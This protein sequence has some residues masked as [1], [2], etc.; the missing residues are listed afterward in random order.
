MAVSRKDNN[1]QTGPNLDRI[2]QLVERIDAKKQVADDARSDLGTIFK[3][4]EDLGH[5]R[6]A[7]KLAIKL[8]NM[9]AGKRT[10]FMTRLNEY[11]DVL[12][13][14]A[15]GDL[16][17]D[18]EQGVGPRQSGDIDPYQAGKK[19]GFVGEAAENNPFDDDEPAHEAWSKGWVAGQAQLLTDTMSSAGAREAATA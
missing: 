16:F 19:A 13:V 5:D 9:E 14:F 2:P 11:L 6:G 8:R 1:V 10:T 12:G 17:S 7:L 18:E 3:E 15:Q 4:V